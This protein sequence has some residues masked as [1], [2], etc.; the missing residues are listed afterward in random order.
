MSYQPF[1]TAHWTETAEIGCIAAMLLSIPFSSGVT[2]AFAV[3]WLLLLILKNSLLKRWSFFG[4]H[5]DKSYQNDKT[6]VFLY[7]MMAYWLLYC[8]SMLWTE[9]KEQG[10]VEIGSLVWMFVFPLMYA[11]TDFRQVTKQHVRLML[12]LFVVSWLLLLLWFE[13]V[14]IKP[15]VQC[16]AEISGRHSKES[17]VNL[18]LRLINACAVGIDDIRVKCEI[19][20]KIQLLENRTSSIDG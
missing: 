14:L 2:L 3:A 4:F 18:P 1:H 9:N 17:M 15:P 5:Q 7:L 10:G 12:W 19:E 8:V 13:G 20:S 6:P 16:Y 11:V